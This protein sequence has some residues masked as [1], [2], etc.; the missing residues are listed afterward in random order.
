MLFISFCHCNRCRNT[1]AVTEVGVYFMLN[2]FTDFD[3]DT[4]ILKSVG[5]LRMVNMN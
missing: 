1:S 4:G 3:D 2:E 5:W